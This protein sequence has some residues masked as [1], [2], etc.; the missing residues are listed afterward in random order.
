AHTVPGGEAPFRPRTQTCGPVLRTH[1]AARLSQCSQVI[2]AAPA[3]TVDDCKVQ[4][5]ETCCA[6]D[7]SCDKPATS[8]ES[9][10]LA[11]SAALGTMTCGTN[12]APAGCAGVVSESAQARIVAQAKGPT[13]GTTAAP[14]R[15]D[16]VE[17]WMGQV[18]AAA[19]GGAVRS[20]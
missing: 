12:T 20:R 3:A 15:Y 1:L 11:C 14:A 4:F 6:T 5:H 18:T 13:S 2:T 17:S 16:T 10:I 7:G 8:L 9:A 19:A